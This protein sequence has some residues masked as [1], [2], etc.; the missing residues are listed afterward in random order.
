MMTSQRTLS[1]RGC[2]VGE[3][4]VALSGC[5]V[6]DSSGSLNYRAERAFL[7]SPASAAREDFSGVARLERRF[8]TH[9]EILKKCMMDWGWRLRS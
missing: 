4:E 1:L 6:R 8:F 7:P 2:G 5:G 3:F 9:D